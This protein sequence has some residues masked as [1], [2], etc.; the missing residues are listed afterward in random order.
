M[1][2]S[3]PAGSVLL[4]MHVEH[5]GSTARRQATPLP[6]PA[7]GPAGQLGR[8]DPAHREP[9]SALSARRRRAEDSERTEATAARASTRNQCRWIRAESCDPRP[10]PVCPIWPPL[11]RRRLRY[12]RL[13]PSPLRRPRHR[14]R[15]AIDC[16]ALLSPLRSSARGHTSTGARAVSGRVRAEPG[17][18]AGI[19]RDTGHPPRVI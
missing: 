15:A 7:P 5:A 12:C 17:A 6:S 4:A 13:G 16:C 14:G 11:R 8:L 19:E 2:P 9:L 18:A 10:G 3:T 1:K